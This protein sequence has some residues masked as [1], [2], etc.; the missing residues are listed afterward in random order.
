MRDHKAAVNSPPERKEDSAQWWKAVLWVPSLTVLV[1]R[2][3]AITGVA[4]NG[5]IRFA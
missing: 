5:S 3:M 2:C 1:T 4:R